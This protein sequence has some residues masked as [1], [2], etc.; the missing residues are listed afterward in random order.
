MP[1]LLCLDLGTSAAKGALI[2]TDGTAIAEA[3]CDYPTRLLDGGG[4]EQE[5]QDWM[6]AAR[7]VITRLLGAHPAH[8]R[9][10]ALGLTGQMQDLVLETEG[11]ADLPA[12]LYSDTRAGYEAEELHAHLERA[13][14][15]WDEVSGNQQD[16]TSCAAMFL[17]RTRTDPQLARRVRRLLFGPAGHLVHRLGL[18][19]WCDSTTAA[20]TGL[21]DARTR[22]WS[23]P[24][25][26]AA[27][28][29]P[30]LLPALTRRAGQ[31]VGRTDDAADELL[32]LPAGIPVVL[33]PGDAGATTLGIVGLDPGDAYLSLGTSGWHAS[34]LAGT[35]T[36]RHSAS[37]HLALAARGRRAGD[38][39]GAP[40]PPTLRISALL[41]AGAAAAWARASLLDGASP[42]E[43]D[44]LLEERERLHGRGPTGLLALP[45]LFGERYPVRDA[46]LRGALV[47]MGPRTRGIDM[48][49]AVLE[50]VAHALA[51][52][53]ISG[54]VD[55]GR[56]DGGRDG[57]G[58][59]GGGRSGPLAL[60]GGG[61]A[62]APWLRIV[63]DVIGRPVRAVDGAD[64]A[65][66]GCAIA[67]ADALDLP[68][69]ILP[70]AARGE[71]RV[72]APDPS[73]AAAHAALRPA[74]RALYTAVA[75]VQALSRE[76]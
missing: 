49:A 67:A 2:S 47:G 21:L 26:E 35:E 57:E 40:A 55:G 32:G 56:V 73:A 10:L 68:S 9:P 46:D 12:V 51:H 31:V 61:A 52:A 44:A 29:E 23:L 5:P 76:C 22:E 1:S 16:A 53:D 74:H 19:A 59:D 36:E 64:A 38:A 50:G 63:A 15:P 18:G 66:V 14:T 24:V 54:R 13:G 8:G 72:V 30:A 45:S 17:R 6:R 11:G 71:G 3:S 37:H 48:Y 7:A 43:A 62:S 42:E 58:R 69:S 41:A 33:A 4:A 70:L 39:D 60:T 28:I 25:A 34:V 27:G 75:E 65:L 20:A